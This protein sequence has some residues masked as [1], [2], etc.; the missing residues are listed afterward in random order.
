MKT[1]TRKEDWIRVTDNPPPK[2]ATWM[3]R[4]FSDGQSPSAV[5]Q[6]APW[7]TQVDKD[8]QPSQPKEPREAPSLI[9]TA[10]MLRVSAS[11][12]QVDRLPDF[13]MSTPVLRNAAGQRIDLPLDLKADDRMINSLRRR[14]PR[15]CNLHHLKRAC[16]NRDCDYDHGTQLTTEEFEA[17][18]YLSR[19]Q[20][21]PFGTTCDNPNCTKGHMCPSGKRCTFGDRCRFPGTHNIDTKPVNEDSNSEMDMEHPLERDTRSHMDWDADDYSQNEGISW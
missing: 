10:P 21:C 15:L 2:N 9:S 6:S 5:V 12:S 1:D 4:Y 13:V 19:S 14:N 18:L 11:K 20:P 16:P 7:R 8:W 3:L 17:L